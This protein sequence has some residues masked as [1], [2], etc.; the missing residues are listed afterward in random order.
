MA[1]EFLKSQKLFRD[2]RQKSRYQHLEALN[3]KAQGSLKHCQPK[4]QAEK[5]GLFQMGK[6]PLRILW[7]GNRF[8]GVYDLTLS[9]IK[10]V[11]QLA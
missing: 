2:S 10:A 7:E 11:R 1:K 8:G 3:Q 4:T 9:L 5:R 6:T